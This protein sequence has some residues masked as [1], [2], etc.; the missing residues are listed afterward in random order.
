MW[1]QLAQQEPIDPA[2]VAALED[3][4]ESLEAVHRVKKHLAEAKAF[5]CVRWI[6][7]TRE[8]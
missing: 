7:T 6:A 1:P 3:R 5:R 4:V 2:R 8:P